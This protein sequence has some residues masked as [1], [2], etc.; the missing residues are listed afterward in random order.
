MSTQRTKEI[1]IRKVMGAD[2]KQI[3][4]LLTIDIFRLIIIAFIVLIPLSYWAMSAWLQ[5]YAT[6]M[7]IGLDLYVLPFIFVLFITILTVGAHVIRAAL[8]NPVEALR[9]E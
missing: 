2:I 6:R 4:F 5:T 1:G 7:N 9:Y 8:A 3:L